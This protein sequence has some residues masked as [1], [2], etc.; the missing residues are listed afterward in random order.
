MCVA[1]LLFEFTGSYDMH[2]QTCMPYIDQYLDCVFVVGLCVC[3]LTVEQCM[4]LLKLTC[5]RFPVRPLT[6][7]VVGLTLHGEEFLKQCL[8]YEPTKRE[9][10]KALLTSAYLVNADRPDAA[11]VEGL[12]R[13]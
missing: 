4:G 12:V 11:G 9:T 5:Q 3:M 1:K 2:M 10:A 13:G 7:W 8:E 6:D